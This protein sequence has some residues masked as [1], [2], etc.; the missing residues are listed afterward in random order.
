MSSM[1]VQPR[2]E[3]LAERPD[4]LPSVAHWIY[5]QWWTSVAGANVNTLTEL[6]RTHLVLDQIPLTLV[7]SAD[8]RP[9]GTATLIA[10]DVGTEQWPDL[11]PWL[12]ALYVV[13]E[14]RGGGVGKAL[15]NAIVSKAAELGAR[16]LHLT[17]VDR[18]GFYARLGWSTIHKTPKKVVMCQRMS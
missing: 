6:L 14:C 10:H 9:I 5:N 18:E 12:A 11:T 16:V 8:S 15:V 13:P 17:T 1:P 7:A 3:Q 4:L 2:I